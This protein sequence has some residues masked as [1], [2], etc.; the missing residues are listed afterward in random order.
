M[1]DSITLSLEKTSETQKMIIELNNMLKI[2]K[3][4]EESK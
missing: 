1:S 4:D 3:K 2:L